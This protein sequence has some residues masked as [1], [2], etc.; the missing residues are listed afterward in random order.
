MAAA[1]DPT[2]DLDE[3]RQFLRQLRKRADRSALGLD[4]PG[5][6]GVSQGEA[7]KL[8]SDMIAPEQVRERWFRKLEL[9]DAPWT[10]RLADAYAA[11]LQLH[12][13]ELDVFYRI[14]KCQP[15]ADTLDGDL[16]APDVSYLQD[17]L[18]APSYL[19]DPYW[20]M[21]ARNRAM[22][23]LVPRFRPGINIFEYVLIDPEA[24]EILVDWEAWA[25]RMIMQLRST[26][27]KS[28]GL[29][30]Q[31]LAAIAR[32]C[33]GD[34]DVARLW[35]VELEPRLSPNGEVRLLRPPDPSSPTG[36]G[37]PIRVTL[38]STAPASKPQWR[39]MS[40]IPLDPLPAAPEPPQEDETR[41]FPRPALLLQHGPLD[42]ADPRAAS[43]A[44]GAHVP[45]VSG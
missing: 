34:K 30:K 40:L 26:L 15:P 2:T 37:E 11:L 4:R 5:E 22:A 24:R 39:Y 16:F 45:P 27:L 25:L 9:L 10:Q 17:T 20:D 38:Y 33:R 12:D 6:R 44:A 23:A 43:A 8:I 31:G 1:G 32:G 28:T 18:A 42:G 29:R 21:R 7:I 14:V 3:A 35:E 19:G 13:S 36:L 41:W